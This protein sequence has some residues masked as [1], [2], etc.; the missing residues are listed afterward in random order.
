MKENKDFGR[1]KKPLKEDGNKSM[2]ASERSSESSLRKGSD[3]SEKASK[4]NLS[5][6]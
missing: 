2:P 6:D 5:N 4:V 1:G 3:S